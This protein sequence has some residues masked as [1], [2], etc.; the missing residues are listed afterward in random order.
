MFP[1]RRN[2]HKPSRSRNIAKGYKKNINFL[3]SET[4]TGNLM[5]ENQL[6]RELNSNPLA[7][8][9]AEKAIKQRQKYAQKPGETGVRAQRPKIIYG[10]PVRPY[11]GGSVGAG[12][13]S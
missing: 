11:Q 5:A 9:V 8:K 4:L 2:H 13:K 3:I 10:N 7:R 12:R 6:R 1:S